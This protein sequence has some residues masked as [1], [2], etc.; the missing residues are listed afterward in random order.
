[1]IKKSG[2][3]RY[4]SSPGCHFWRGWSGAVCYIELL[5]WMNSHDRKSR[6]V[7]SVEAQQINSNSCCC[8]SKI[9]G[10]PGQCP[11]WLKCP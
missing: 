5:L 1:M 10:V 4:P 11:W 2:V 8:S 6:S 9:Y 7:G 3:A